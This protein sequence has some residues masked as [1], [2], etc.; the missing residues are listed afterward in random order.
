ME[1]DRSQEEAIG[2]NIRGNRSQ[3]EANTRE[4]KKIGE[5]TSNFLR[6]ASHFV[7]LEPFWGAS[8]PLG[9]FWDTFRS[10]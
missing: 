9:R 2:T 3:I 10:L 4:N 1:G 6:K 7:F 5:K 8:E